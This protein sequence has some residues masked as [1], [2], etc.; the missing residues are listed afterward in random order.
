MAT[1]VGHGYA[2]DSYLCLLAPSEYL[3]RLSG[4]V[5]NQLVPFLLSH[6]TAVDGLR[7]SD[8]LNK[9]L[10]LQPTH[11]FIQLVSLDPIGAFLVLAAATSE[12][13]HPRM[14]CVPLRCHL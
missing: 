3:Q 7:P 9:L 12:V 8:C 2:I 4:V 6:T 11:F 1:L 10:F 13:Q 14:G 5:S